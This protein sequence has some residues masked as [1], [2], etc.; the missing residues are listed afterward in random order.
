MNAPDAADEALRAE[1]AERAEKGELLPSCH[2][3]Y[4]QTRRLD[5]RMTRIEGI[6]V[7]NGV[8]GLD[9]TVRNTHRDHQLTRKWI[10]AIAVYTVASNPFA[11]S[12]MIQTILKY[13][14]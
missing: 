4:H 7:G 9:E 13:V 12:D 10:Y 3:H 5:R 6:L 8:V 2:M 1:L 14:R 11:I